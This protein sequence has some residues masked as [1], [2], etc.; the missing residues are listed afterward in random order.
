[1]ALIIAGI[2]AFIHQKLASIDEFFEERRRKREFDNAVITIKR[3]FIWDGNDLTKLPERIDD[4]KILS[5]KYPLRKNQSLTFDHLNY[6]N[7]LVEI[8]YE[9]FDKEFSVIYNDKT[10]IFPPIDPKIKPEDQGICT[11]HSLFSACYCRIT[12]SDIEDNVEIEETDIVDSIKHYEGLFHS[13]HIHPSNHKSASI[14]DVLKIMH[15]VCSIIPESPSQALEIHFGKNAQ[16]KTIEEYIQ[17]MQSMNKI[18]SSGFLKLG[19][20][21]QTIIHPSFC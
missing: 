4:S 5:T 13:F 9:L 18:H 3:I 14:Q 2:K 16:Y 20:I 7:P 12:S 8:H 6:E 1:M 19:L 17:N 15:S 21:N 11:E 10:I